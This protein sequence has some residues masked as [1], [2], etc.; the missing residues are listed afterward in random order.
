MDSAAFLLC[1]VFAI[2]HIQSL[3]ADLPN[4]AE[5]IGGET[6]N[7][8]TMALS[9][10]I[11][12]NSMPSDGSVRVDSMTMI[13][14][15]EDEN[16]QSRIDPHPYIHPSIAG[17][18]TV[19]QGSPSVMHQ[20]VEAP[21]VFPWFKFNHGHLFQKLLSN[22]ST[23]GVEEFMNIT[24]G[25][26]NYTIAEMKQK[27]SEWANENGVMEQL[28]MFKTKGE[29]K[30]G[31]IIANATMIINSLPSLFQQLVGIIQNEQQTVKDGLNATDAYLQSLDPATKQIMSVVTKI[32][33]V[34]M[35]LFK[36]H[37]KSSHGF[38]GHFDMFRRGGDHRPVFPERNS[39]SPQISSQIGDSAAESGNDN[40][41]AVAGVQSQ[42]QSS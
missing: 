26:E 29:S 5:N 22:I 23:E 1:F 6:L 32:T 7:Q 42:Q 38:T 13:D 35:F 11:N 4:Q 36:P 37:H 17:T 15:A 16:E 34:D 21:N 14:P 3:V 30:K 9:R 41:N 40:E 24:L 12:H 19:P 39:F 10:L 2:A 20:T 25:A 27:M 31:E 18:L 8:Q 33:G 28:D